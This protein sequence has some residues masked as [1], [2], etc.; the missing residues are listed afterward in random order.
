MQPLNRIAVTVSL[1]A[2]LGGCFDDPE[3]SSARDGAS[4]GEVPL[5][6]GASAPQPSASPTPADSSRLSL[7]WVGTYSGVV[8]CAS[9]PGIE[10]SITLNDDG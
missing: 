2:I 3:T 9:C 1:V 6:S 7:D 8:P 10:T 5:S 4:E